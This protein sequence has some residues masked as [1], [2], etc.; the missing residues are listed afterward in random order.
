[1]EPKK[2][3]RWLSDSYKK[4]FQR[5][6]LK[7]FVHKHASYTPMHL[8]AHTRRSKR[9]SQEFRQNF[10]HSTRRKRCRRAGRG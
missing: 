4:L 9:L 8:R 6:K 10:R 3:R 2:L 5:K 1:M 7:R